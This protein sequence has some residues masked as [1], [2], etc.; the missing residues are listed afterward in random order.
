MNTKSLMFFFFHFF[1][2][3]CK[4]SNFNMWTAYHL[5]QASCTEFAL[6][7]KVQEEHPFCDFWFQCILMKYGDHEYWGLFLV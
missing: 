5:A 7:I 4:V 1:H 3:I 6:E 2:L